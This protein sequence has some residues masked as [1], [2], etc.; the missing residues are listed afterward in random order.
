MNNKSQAFWISPS[1]KIIDVPQFHIST[2]MDDP[3]KFNTSKEELQ[4]IFAKYNEPYSPFVEGF[5]REE[6]M[7][8]LIK[9][10]W[11]RLRYVSKSNSWTIQLANLNN[12]LK[13]YIFDWVVRM[14]DKR[15]MSKRTGIKILPIDGQN[16]ISGDASEVINFKLFELH[17]MSKP[18][19][20]Y[21]VEFCSLKKFKPSLLDFIG[22]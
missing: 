1:G 8:Q 7:V 4:Q 13:N 20:K 6:I 21:L 5:A 19:C 3:E 22:C 10:G 17:K 11:V 16:V 9:K 2:V 14:I 15:K 12:R 18:N